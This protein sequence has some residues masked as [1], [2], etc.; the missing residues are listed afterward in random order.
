MRLD[1]FNKLST[2]EEKT[3]ISQAKDLISFQPLL[4]DADRLADSSLIAAGVREQHL[5]CGK[6]HNIL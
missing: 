2:K 4:L 1:V 3:Q 6:K 5:C